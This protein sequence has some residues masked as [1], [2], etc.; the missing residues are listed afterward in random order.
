MPLVL[1]LRL[2]EIQKQTR[3]YG[4]D[5]M[6]AW[7]ERAAKNQIPETIAKFYRGLTGFD[8]TFSLFACDHDRY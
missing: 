2:L 3:V 7:C 8:D 1:G 5:L 6:L 4:P